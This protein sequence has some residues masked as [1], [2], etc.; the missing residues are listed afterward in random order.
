MLNQVMVKSR[1]QAIFSTDKLKFFLDD[2]IT[3]RMRNAVPPK[4]IV[5]TYGSSEES[6]WPASDDDDQ[7]FFAV[8]IS[9][10]A[11]NMF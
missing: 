10:A 4:R 11:K 5:E 6:L 9:A 7:P 8:N 1:R 3:R 2:Y